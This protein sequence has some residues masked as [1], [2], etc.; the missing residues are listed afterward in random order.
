MDSESRN[1]VQVTTGKLLDALGQAAESLVY[2]FQ[3]L[4]CC[5]LRAQRVFEGVQV[6]QPLPMQAAQLVEL[7]RNAWGVVRMQ[8]WICSANRAGPNISASIY[9]GDRKRS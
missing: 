6:G 5:A 4:G 7:A 1:C 3:H 9:K 2:A 8:R